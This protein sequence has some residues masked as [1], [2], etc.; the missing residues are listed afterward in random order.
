MGASC[1]A[2]QA[3]S[4]CLAVKPQQ[5]Q[6]PQQSKHRVTGRARNGLAPAAAEAPGRISSSG[7][8]PSRALL[9]KQN[10]PS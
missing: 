7:T 8:T 2:T 1:Q 4:R 10:T 6:G 5:H 3:S 9:A